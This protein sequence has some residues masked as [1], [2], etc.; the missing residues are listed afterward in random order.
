[1]DPSGEGT[2]ARDLELQLRELRSKTN[3][4]EQCIEQYKLET[5]KLMLLSENENSSEVAHGMMRVWLRDARQQSDD[6][7]SD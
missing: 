4:Q 5:Q 6:L 1:M 2:C 3:S 7:R